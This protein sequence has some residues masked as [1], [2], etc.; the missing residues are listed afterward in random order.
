MRRLLL[1]H[2]AAEKIRPHRLPV[3][4]HLLLLQAT[5]RL[6]RHPVAKEKH[7]HLLR[8]ATTVHRHLHPAD[9]EQEHLLLHPAVRVQAH[10]HLHPVVRD[11]VHILLH[12]HLKTV[13][14]TFRTEVT[15][16][17]MVVRVTT[18]TIT[19]SVT[20]QAGKN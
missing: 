20:P 11:R 16:S 12:L 8:A 17:V 7:L 5:D 19:T 4:A 2:P 10:R 13:S 15:E 6:H 3:T 9:R 14:A 18:M 1:P